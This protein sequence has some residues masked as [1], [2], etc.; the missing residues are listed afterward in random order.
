MPAVWPSYIEN[1][2]VQGA[3]ATAQH[4][5]SWSEDSLYG[6]ELHAPE[7]D[8][9]AAT[10]FAVVH[11]HQKACLLLVKA[12]LVGSATA[13]MRPSVEV[14]VRGLWLQWATD[15]ELAR[16][17]K[18]EDSINLE[19]AIKLIVQRSNIERYKDLLGMW[20]LSKNTLHG[21]VHHGYQ[22]LIRR[23]GQIDVPPAEIVSLLNFSSALATHASIELTELA[24][25]RAIPGQEAARRNL[26]NKLQAELVATLGTLSLAD[27]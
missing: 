13:L 4:V 22:S 23:S 3:L 2:G 19:R 17:Q 20:A 25:K 7:P 16:F 26:V 18:G 21:Y 15:E 14:F 9:M 24:D 11:E 5:A 6:L 12:G 8:H 10:A 1:A 27:I